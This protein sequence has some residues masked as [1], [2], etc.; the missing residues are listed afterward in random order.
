MTTTKEQDKIVVEEVMDW[1]E[2]M[3]RTIERIAR[4]ADCHPQLVLE[5]MVRM[6]NQLREDMINKYKEQG[7]DVN[8]EAGI[9]TSD[10]V[11]DQEC[12]E[13]GR[14]DSAESVTLTP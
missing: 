10:T 6:A 8:E 7:V 12:D 5:F 3:G 11:K 14:S 9:T 1:F 4:K 2:D 13:K